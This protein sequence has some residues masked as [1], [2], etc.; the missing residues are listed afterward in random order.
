MNNYIKNINANQVFLIAI[1]TGFVLS[2]AIKIA[3]PA[4]SFVLTLILCS[5]ILIS[6]HYFSYK[7][8]TSDKYRVLSDGRKLTESSIVDNCYYLGFTF[9][10]VILT[11]SFLN[12]THDTIAA[13]HSY[14]QTYTALIMI[15]NRFCIGLFT[16]GY[17][18]VA[19]IHL[20]N[21]IEIEELDPE[22]LQNRLNTRT[23]SLINVIDS[24]VH[25]LTSLVEQSTK[26]VEGTVLDSNESIRDKTTMLVA[27]VS[28]LTNNLMK[29]TKKIEAQVPN[30]EMTGATDA[31]L[32]HLTATADS[33][34]N[35]NSSI[36]KIRAS[37]DEADKTASTASNK[38]SKDLVL[39]SE[40]YSS[41]A[42][43]MNELKTEFQKLSS[44]ISSSDAAA[45]NFMASVQLLDA[46][47]R[48]ANET[49]VGLGGAATS[50]GEKLNSLSSQ[51][52]ESNKELS[53]VQN[54]VNSIDVNTNKKVD[55]LNSTVADVI[56]SL[57][58][59]VNSLSSQIT[60]LDETLNEVKRKFN[61]LSIDQETKRTSFWGR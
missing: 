20:S 34:N 42:S 31:V 39:I 55:E 35:L 54:I 33:V 37:F 4:D 27:E 48:K 38:V 13:K 61:N 26:N 28:N 58:G 57:E 16:T 44:E 1:F 43:Q 36:Q 23:Q 9:T 14:D 46:G 5:S 3:M 49:I 40:Q 52:T 32:S 59:R 6:F 8:I 56:R 60:S 21:L 51:I 10:I 47:S 24:G 41:I 18:L 25:S 7:S 15:L 22:G 30:F 17:G 29:I 11:T 2:T 19:R 45:K 50:A 53:R 12:T